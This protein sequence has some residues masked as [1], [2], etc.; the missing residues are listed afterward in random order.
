[1]LRLAQAKTGSVVVF[2]S[3]SGGNQIIRKIT[4][5]GLIPGEKIKI[6]QNSGHG[7]V[8]VCIKGGKFAIGHGFAKKIAVREASYG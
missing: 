6:I 7:Q 8:T 1:M 3:A 4:D 5:L 2:L